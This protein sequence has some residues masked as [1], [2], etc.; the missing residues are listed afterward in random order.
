VQSASA[1]IYLLCSNRP[2]RKVSCYAGSL[3]QLFS[4]VAVA[5]KFAFAAISHSVSVRETKKG[6]E[7]V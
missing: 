6:V 5:E 3:T 1:S 4:V 7:M 2:A